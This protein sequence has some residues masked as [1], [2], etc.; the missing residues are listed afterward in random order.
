MRKKAG[1]KVEAAVLGA[2]CVCLSVCLGLVPCSGSN[3]RMRQP[4]RVSRQCERERETDRE[5]GRA[6]AGAQT[7]V[8]GGSVY[9][10][11]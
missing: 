5:P 1:L 11:V 9:E 6:T 10:C 7:A 4:A 8:T 3:D 2:V